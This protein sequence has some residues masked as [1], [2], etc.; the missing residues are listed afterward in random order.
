MSKINHFCSIRNAKIVAIIFLLGA[1]YITNLISVE[2]EIKPFQK[3]YQVQL[4]FFDQ[5]LYSLGNRLSLRNRKVNVIPLL[6]V[7][8]WGSLN[9][10]LFIHDTDGKKRNQ[11]YV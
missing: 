11:V 10:A 6:L 4:Q 5:I 3:M 8:S 2:K 9:M 1:Y 7:G